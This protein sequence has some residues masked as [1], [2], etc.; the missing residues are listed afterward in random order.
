MTYIVCKD[1][2]L[3]GINGHFVLKVGDIL[4]ENNDIISY[5]G[6]NICY[7]TAQVA[8]NYF[9]R[10]DDGQG[11]KRYEA[12]HAIMLK[13]TELK[14]E[15]RTTIENIIK[16]L[17]KDAT[18]EQLKE[19]TKDVFDKGSYIYDNL[20]PKFKIDNIYSVDFYNT[21]I[22]ELEHIAEMIES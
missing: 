15:Y 8:Y 22:E 19:A 13:I 14:T 9:S 7:K 12:V 17:P 21:S 16:K 18:V 4:D 5:E 3:N 2:N 10:N 6:R 1:C 20:D 11:L